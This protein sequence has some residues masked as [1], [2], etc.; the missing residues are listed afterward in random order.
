ML[1][2]LSR[3]LL[4]VFAEGSAGAYWLKLTGKDFSSWRIGSCVRGARAVRDT[5]GKKARDIVPY[6]W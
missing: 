2:C 4:Y 5:H 6:S 3:H 1:P